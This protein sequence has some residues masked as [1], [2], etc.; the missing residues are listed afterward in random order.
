MLSADWTRLWEVVKDVGNVLIYIE[1][2]K[3]NGV[4]VRDRGKQWEDNWRKVG[5]T[6]KYWEENVG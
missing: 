2:S 6:E 4:K 3:K 1:V 5:S